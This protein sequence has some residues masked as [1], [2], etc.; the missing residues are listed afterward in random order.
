MNPG[1]NAARHL[2][3]FRGRRA[4]RER[5]APYPR[6]SLMRL[7]RESGPGGKKPSAAYYRVKAG[8]M[9]EVAARTEFPDTR[10]QLLWIACQ[11]E[12]LAE[13]H[14]RQEAVHAPDRPADA[15]RKD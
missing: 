9:R 2:V 5:S 4:E 15:L 3:S 6:Y 7:S 11:Y 13:R 14:E 8:A 10:E 12:Q 1:G